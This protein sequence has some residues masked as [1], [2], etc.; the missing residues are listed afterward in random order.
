MEEFS[1]K[2]YIEKKMIK[3]KIYITGTLI[4]ASTT[5]SNIRTIFDPFSIL[6]PDN[7]DIINF[8]PLTILGDLRNRKLPYEYPNR[9][10]NLNNSW[11]SLSSSYE[12]EYGFEIPLYVGNDKHYLMFVSELDKIMRLNLCRN[13]Y[14]LEEMRKLFKIELHCTIDIEKINPLYDLLLNKNKITKQYIFEEVKYDHGMLNEDLNN[15]NYLNQNHQ[16]R[17]DCYS[18][19]EIVFSIFY[20]IV[21][22]N[23]TFETCALCQKRYAKIPTQG[24]VKCCTRRNQLNLEGY[25]SPKKCQANSNPNCTETLELIKEQIRNDKKCIYTHMDRFGKQNYSRFSDTFDKYQK[26]LNDN[27]TVKNLQKLYYLVKKENR[28]IWY[29][30]DGKEFE[31]ELKKMMKTLDNWN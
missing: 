29:L 1:Y 18:V 22:H 24:K 3:D 6:Y 31:Y 21:I 26:N 14:D 2:V 27:H 19:A 10:L 28:Y 13:L 9:R 15:Y 4:Q 17:Y 12:F 7:P 11:Q 23:Y 5:T 30:K 16:F 25:L 20:F 8:D